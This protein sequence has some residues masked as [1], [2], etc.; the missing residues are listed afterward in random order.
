MKTFSVITLTGFHLTHPNSLI[1]IILF[2]F[3]LIVGRPVDRRADRRV[4]GGLLPVR[5]GR[6]RY[7]HHQGVGHRHEVPRA[8][9]DR[10]RASGHDQ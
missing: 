8:E 6:R 3:S 7:H 4:Q 1:I 9:P 10:G 2:Y 5:Q